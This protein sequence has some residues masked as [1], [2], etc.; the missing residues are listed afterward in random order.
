MSS[1]GAMA[2]FPI[3]F[4]AVMAKVDDLSGVPIVATLPSGDATGGELLERHPVLERLKRP[5]PG[6]SGLFFRRQLILDYSLC[7][8]AYV[9]IR[10]G[11]I[12]EPW[13]RLHPNKVEPLINSLGMLVGYKH[14]RPDGSARTLMPHEVLRVANP[15]WEDTV[16]AAFGVSP[17]RALHDTLTARL[18]AKQHAANAAQAG[19]PDVIVSPG[20]DDVLL[21]GQAPEQIAAAIDEKLSNGDRVLVMPAPLKLEMMSYTPRDLEFTD[22]HAIGTYEILAVLGVPPQRIHLEGA[23]YGTSRQALRTYWQSL[24][25]VAALFDDEFSRLAEDGVRIKHQFAN[26]E[27]LQISRSERLKRVLQWVMLGATPAKAA[28]FE[29]FDNAPVPDELIEL[30]NPGNVST[31]PVADEPQDEPQDQQGR[32]SLARDLVDFHADVA[33]RIRAAAATH[34]GDPDAWTLDQREQ[35]RAL[36]VFDDHFDVERA[37]SVAS[38]W[39]DLVETQVRRSLAEARAE[40][41]TQIGPLP[42]FGARATRRVAHHLQM[43]AA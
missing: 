36:T 31:G 18:A 35:L 22:L 40:G 32:R 26:V 25:H 3:V 30:V 10:N 21:G 17:I 41:V 9:Y 8:N 37:I 38:A 29:G 16:K 27:A 4:A 23:N 39:S 28:A 11:D 13:L 43:E 24:I 42:L 34:E 15:S 7:G 12:L 14:T 2:R 6:V 33:D 19:R 5:A 20:S 1:M